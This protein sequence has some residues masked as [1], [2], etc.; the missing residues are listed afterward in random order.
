MELI[1]YCGLKCSE[2]TSFPCALIETFMV[3]IYIEEASKN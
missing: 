1:A 2:C 3:S